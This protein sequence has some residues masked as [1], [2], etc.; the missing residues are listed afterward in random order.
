MRAGYWGIVIVGAILQVAT[1]L[2]AAPAGVQWLP[3]EKRDPNRIGDTIDTQRGNERRSD[4]ADAPPQML[5]T[6]LVGSATDEAMGRAIERYQRIVAA[7]GWQPIPAGP[8][9]KLNTRGNRVVYLRRRLQATG[10]LAEVRGDP[11]VFNQNV[12]T[13][14]ERFQLRHGLTPSGEVNR[15]TL[16]AL[17]QSAQQLLHRLQ[18]NRQRLRSLAAQ[19]RGRRYILVNIPAY[20]L[21]AVTNGRLDLSSAVV[22]GKPATPTP[23]VTAAVRAVDFMPYWNVPQS[24]AQRALIPAVQKDPA[25]L[26]RERIRVFAGYGGAE[27]NST[28]VNWRAPQGDRLFFRQDPGPFNALGLIRLDMPNQHT[29]YMHDT[30]LKKLFKF[31]LRPYSAGCVRVQKIQELT[32]WL[33]SAVGGWDAVRLTD[34]LQAGQQQTI[35]LPQPVPVHFVYVSAWATG[36]GDAQFRMDIYD[37]DGSAARTAEAEDWDARPQP[38]AP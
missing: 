25:Y 38:V 13:A 14:L 8:K 10:D 34:A 16:R 28:Q 29:V 9:L 33:L 15:L 22:V 20:E 17:N 5:Q 19:T 23:E 2:P 3:W 6:V 24:I 35:P 32:L 36:A 4:Q 12:A 30:P 18:V 21:Q 1:A 7:G 37:K 26:D 31:Y 27:L 11:R